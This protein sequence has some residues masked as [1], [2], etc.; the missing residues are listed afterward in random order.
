MNEYRG[1]PR[2]IPRPGGKVSVTIGESIS[3]KIQPL[4]DRWRAIAAAEKGDLGVGGEW[5][6][7]D[8][9][10]RVVEDLRQR[11]VRSRGLLAGSKEEAIRIEITAAIQEEVRKLGERV[12]SEEGR[13]ERGDWSQSRRAPATSGDEQ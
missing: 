2:P 7:A 6:A 12:E 10:A 11:E 1:F 3:H 5:K 13:F 8:G 4:V 9:E